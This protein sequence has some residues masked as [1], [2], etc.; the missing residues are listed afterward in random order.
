MRVTLLSV[1]LSQ[2]TTIKMDV[3]DDP[4][5]ERA[6]LKVNSSGRKVPNQY[7][8][9]IM[10]A[11]LHGALDSGELQRC[12]AV[13]KLRGFTTSSGTR[14]SGTAASCHAVSDVGAWK[15]TTLR[16]THLLLQLLHLHLPQ[17]LHAFL[18]PKHPRLPT[19]KILVPGQHPGPYV[20]K[21][22]VL[23]DSFE[24]ANTAMAASGPTVR[25]RVLEAKNRA[26]SGRLVLK[27][28]K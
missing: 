22:R 18:P 10:K 20:L 2:K 14:C 1:R 28:A 3:F 17:T 6:L 13:H 12:R 16:S 5:L 7:S 11:F 26:Q 8:E 19:P 9:A 21:F 25:V 4:V 27:L 23:Q 24:A 15:K